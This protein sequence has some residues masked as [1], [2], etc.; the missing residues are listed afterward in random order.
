M[1]I[2]FGGVEYSGIHIGGLD[3]TGI[4]VSGSSFIQSDEPGNLT[5]SARRTSGRT[6]ITF[7]ITDPNGI[8]ALTSAS[9]AARDGTRA[10]FLGDFSRDDANTFSGDDTR[11]NARW[12]R[13]TLTVVYVDAA[14]GRSHTLI[15]TWSV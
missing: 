8:R 4:Q 11:G 15:Q 9:A 5:V 10:D 12:N 13:G 1:G 14:S 2:Y 3:F 6:T 7:S